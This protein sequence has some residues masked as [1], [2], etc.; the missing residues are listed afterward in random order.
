MMGAVVGV[1]FAIALLLVLQGR[2]GVNAW[3]CGEG[4]V[5]ERWLC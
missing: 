3:G 4:Q 2:V 1:G 5:Q